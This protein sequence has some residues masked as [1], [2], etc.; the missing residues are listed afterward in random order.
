MKNISRAYTIIGGV[1]LIAVAVGLFFLMNSSYSSNTSSDMF[2]S[3]EV[4][5]ISINGHTVRAWIA[6]T[7]AAQERGLMHV[8]ALPADTGMLFVFSSLMPR[9]FWN[10]N[11]LIPLDLLWIREGKI[12]GISALPAEPEA[13]IVHV[14]SGEVVDMVLEVPRGWVEVHKVK[15]G[16]KLIFS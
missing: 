16:N 3:Y 10:K 13:G 9:A 5:T 2:E 6:N 1:L 15:I 14:A 11:T 12:V 4:K 7:Q 8:E